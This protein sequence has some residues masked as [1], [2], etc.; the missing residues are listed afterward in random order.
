MMLALKAIPNWRGEHV[1]AGPS[2]IRM[3][4]STRNSWPVG[5][6]ITVRGSSAMCN[7]LHRIPSLGN[8]NGY[9]KTT[10]DFL[11][12]T[13]RQNASPIWYNPERF[14]WSSPQASSNTLLWPSKVDSRAA[15][16]GFSNFVRDTTLWPSL[17]S[18]M[19]W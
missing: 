7:S 15:R 16:N 14:V 4:N 9:P 2:D 18:S 3:T 5:H 11:Q 19:A 10:A 8:I 1:L 13:S 17:S 12:R 6:F